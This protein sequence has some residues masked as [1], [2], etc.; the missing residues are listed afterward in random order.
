M[1]MHVITNRAGEIIAAGPD[2]VVTPDGMTVKIYP[3]G[4]GHS[5]HEIDVVDDIMKILEKDTT[6]FSETIKRHLHKK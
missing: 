3:V 5:L 6:E 4:E 2:K 1:K